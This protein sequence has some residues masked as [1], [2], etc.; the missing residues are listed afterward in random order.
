DPVALILHD[1]FDVAFFL[2]PRGDADA[3]L[4]ESTDRLAFVA[5]EEKVGLFGLSQ[6][7]IGLALNLIV[8]GEPAELQGFDPM[9]AVKN[10][11][12]IV[13]PTHNGKAE[14]FKFKLGCDRLSVRLPELSLCL[15]RDAHVADPYPA[16]LRCAWSLGVGH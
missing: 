3:E 11:V 10:P 5:A 15:G 4:V 8:G 9:L 7:P 14:R 1:A 12:V 6:I 16:E 13:T 2:S